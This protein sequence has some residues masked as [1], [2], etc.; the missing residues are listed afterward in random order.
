MKKTMKN[1]IYVVLLALLM[2]ISSFFSMGFT[3]ARADSNTVKF[4]ETNVM[5]DLRSSKNFNILSYPFYVSEKPEMYIMNVVEYCYSF[6]VQKQG[7]YGLYLYIYNPNGRNIDISEGVNKVEMAA[8]Y[9]SDGT[10]N[11]YEKFDLKFCSKSE[12]EFYKGLFYKFKVVDHKSL[13][14]K[15][16]LQR[17]KSS[18]RR[19]DISGIEILEQGKTLPVEYGV[20]GTYTFKGY[21]EGYGALVTENSLTCEVKELETIQLEVH[22]TN[23]RTGEYQTNHRHDLTSVYFS[24]PQRFFDDYG[25]LQKIKAEW[26][27]YETNPIAITSNTSLYNSLN[28]QIGKNATTNDMPISLYSGYQQLVGSNGHYNSYNFGY[29]VYGEVHDKIDILYYVFSTN[30]ADISKYTLSASRI[31]SYIENYNKTFVNGTINI[32][33]KKI[34]AD[35]FSKDL[36][37][38]RK[39]VAY[40]GNDIHHKLVNIDANDEFDML[41]YQESNSG[42]K[43]FF[44][45]LFGLGPSEVSQSYKGISPIHIVTD[46]ERNG[47]NISTTLLIDNSDSA[48]SEFTNF[49]DTEKAKGNKTVLFRFAQTDYEAIPVIAYNEHTGTNISKQYGKDTFVVRESVF[50]NFDIIELTFS[51]EGKYTVIPVVS[52]PIDI[53]NDIT[54]PEVEDP[55]AWLETLLAIVLLV[56]L[57]VF[58]WVTGLLPFVLKAIGWIILLPFRIIAWI[59]NAITKTVK[60]R[61]DKEK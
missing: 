13:D 53:Y 28:E 14:G 49:Y 30:G 25:S 1:K 51:K 55:W 61:N 43:R 35:L 47:A 15:T 23:F 59:V 48:L 22:K 36:D 26:Y 4:D 57:F 27:E 31:Q 20:G 10:P 56:L 42:W 12:E 60:N 40:V 38:N 33:G 39:S 44:A 7:N 18:A 52:S 17:V 24:V 19:Y 3:S 41:N 8:G 45:G 2:L 54:L 50:L 5:D 32:P 29:N 21:A 11:C 46:E 37:A 58:L 6:D 34:S 16:I 9:D